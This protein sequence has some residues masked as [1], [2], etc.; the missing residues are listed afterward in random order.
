M[1]LLKA[2]TQQ[3]NDYSEIYKHIENILLLAL[4]VTPKLYNHDL[5]CAS[6]FFADF[7]MAAAF[8]AKP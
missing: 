5:Y 2:F 8:L 7:K 4:S 3:G 1:S 6:T